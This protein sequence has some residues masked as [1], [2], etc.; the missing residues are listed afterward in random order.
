M[1]ADD[2]PSRLRGMHVPDGRVGYTQAAALLQHT[3]QRWQH[4]PPRPVRLVLA[5]A[6]AADGSPSPAVQA[7]VAAA[8]DKLIPRAPPDA[9]FPDGMSSVEVLVRLGIAI[10]WFEQL[11]APP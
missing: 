1:D 3:R 5:E 6:L 4:G 10:R 11:A 2:I 7:V 9:A 8:L